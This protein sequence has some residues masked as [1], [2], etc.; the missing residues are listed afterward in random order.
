MFEAWTGLFPANLS[1][2]RVSLAPPSSGSVTSFSARTS[3]ATGALLDI[4][5]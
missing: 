3:A 1:V 2:P 5:E 4:V